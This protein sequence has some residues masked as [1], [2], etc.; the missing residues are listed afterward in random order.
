MNDKSD[1]MTFTTPP[2]VLVD[3]MIGN[4]PLAAMPPRDDA[5]GK[6]GGANRLIGITSGKNSIL[7][8][9]YRDGLR[10]TVTADHDPN[11]DYWTITG[12]Y[13]EKTRIV[14]TV[15]GGRW[16]TDCY[17]R[18]LRNAMA[19]RANRLHGIKYDSATAADAAKE[20]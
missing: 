2:E 5:K 11:T 9:Y 7:A 20:A 8:W 18:F 17:V 4:P 13:G 3:A 16:A 1:S 10:I 19:S 14:A 12:C 6:T 15:F